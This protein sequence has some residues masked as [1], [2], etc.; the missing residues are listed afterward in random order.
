MDDF[1]IELEKNKKK[2]WIL[3]SRI[4]SVAKRKEFST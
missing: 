2:K 3:C 1:Q 4:R